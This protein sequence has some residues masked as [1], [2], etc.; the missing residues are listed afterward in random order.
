MTQVRLQKFLAE[1]G[2]GSRRKMEQFIKEGRVQVN[3]QVVTELGRKIDPSVDQVE[4]NRRPVK[5]APKGIILF[6]KPRG[7]VSTLHDPEGRRTVSEFLTKHYA[8]YFPVGRLDFDSTGL[9]I[10]TND[11]EMAEKLM[12]PRFG[13]ERS[14]EARV[15]GSVP[16]PLLDKLESG[17]RLSDGLVKAEATVIRSDENSTWIEVRIKEG[18]NRIVRRLFEKLGHSVMKL[19]RVVYGPF[20]LGRLQVGQVRVLTA[21]EFLEVR[22]KVMMFKGEESSAPEK[23]DR[24]KSSYRPEG[25]LSDWEREHPRHKPA[26][27]RDDTERPRS[28]KARSGKFDG[29]RQRSD[30]Q[31]SDRPRSDR[32]RSDRQR[33][34]SRSSEKTRSDSARSERPRFDRS[35]SERTDSERPKSKG[36]GGRSQGSLG[37]RSSGGRSSP[38]TRSEGG[39]SRVP[40]GR[41][42]GF[43]RGGRSGNARPGGARKGTRSR[44][45][46]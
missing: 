44:R 45:D 46:D 22:R 26:S 34:D 32:Q 10:L 37:S 24:K 21:R 2:T 40:G 31:R 7:V 36:S 29:D 8:S 4:V 5:A 13:F 17:I 39:K 38:G 30:R 15:E 41:S 9:I 18:R 43:K 25:R 23:G 6:N 35:R 12:H 27:E 11:G 33:S 1:C 3:G 19:K 14:Y 16:Q 42:S 28:E 20:K